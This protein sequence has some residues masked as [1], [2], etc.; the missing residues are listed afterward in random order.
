MSALTERLSELRQSPAFAAN[1]S[2][3]GKKLSEEDGVTVAVGLIE[4]HF[5]H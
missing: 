4:E 1:A 2:A 3:L 5:C